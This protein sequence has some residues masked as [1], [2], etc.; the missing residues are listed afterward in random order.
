MIQPK[1]QE[2]G[3]MARM[4]FVKRDSPAAFTY[5]ASSVARAASIL[6]EFSA[7]LLIQMRMRPHDSQ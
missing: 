1:N 7:S 5:A 4:Q 6:S 2:F 3:Y